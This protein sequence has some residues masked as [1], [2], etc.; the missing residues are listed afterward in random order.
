MRFSFKKIGSVLASTAMLTSTVALAAAANFPAPFVA[1]GAADVA[2][3]HGGANAAF[4]DLVAVTDIS[5]YLST[6]LAKQTATG[7]GGTGA[8]P[9]ITG[10]AAPLFSSGTKLYINDTLNAVKS[11]VTK[12]DL[13]TV[14]KDGSFSGNV[15]ASYTQAIDVGFNPQIIYA[16]KQPTSDLDP[17]FLVQ[18]STTTANYIYNASLT[19]SKAVALN[20]S[21]S[22]GQ[23][24][25]MFG[26]KFT[27]ASATGPTDLVLLKTA[28]KVALT[29]DDPSAEVTISGKTYTIELISAS[30]TAATVKVTDSDGKSETKEISENASKKVNGVTI[31]ITNAD[32]TNLRLSANVI[33]GAEKITIPGTQGSSVTMGEEETVIDGTAVTITGGVGAA[34][35]IVVSVRAP[36][37]DKDGILPGTSFK[38]PVFGSFKLD[39][40]GLSIKDDDTVNREDIKV[41]YNGDD[42]M[43]VAFTNKD[44]KTATVQYAK[45]W[46]AQGGIFGGIQLQRDSD[47]HNITIREGE[48][49]YK[50]NYVV[51]GNED[52]GKL[53]R[54]SQITNSTTAGTSG[55]KVQFVDIFS[56]DTIEAT[57]TAD[58]V[59][60]VSVGGKVYD[61]RYNGTSSNAENLV[62]LNYPDSSGTGGM[63]V[64]PT[65]QTKG[66]AKLSFYEPL[67]VPVTDWDNIDIIVSGG[68]GRDSGLSTLGANLTTIRFPDGDGYTDVTVGGN[69]NEGLFNITFGSTTTALNATGNAAGVASVSGAIGTLSYNISSIDTANPTATHWANDAHNS[70]LRI[71]LNNPDGGAAID[72]PAIVLFEEKDDNSLYQAII[73][74]TEPGGDSNDGVGV[75]DIKRTWQADGTWDAIALASNSKITKEA[76]LFG[77][78][79]TVD[80]GDSDQ[81]RGTINYPAEQVYANVY[82]AENA[83]EISAGQAG[84][85]GAT[86]VTSLGSV[87][88][89]DTEASSVATK[90]LV[91][92][93]GSCVNTV[94]SQ[95]LGLSGK[96]CGA[97]FTAKTGIGAGQ[98][99]IET[100]S[101]TGDKVATLVAG[102]NAGDTTNAAKYLTTQTVDTMVGKK[103]KGTSSTSAEL[104]TEAAAPA[105]A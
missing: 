49:L 69:R 71:R 1:S 91:V 43:E 44:G 73:V 90:N 96:T 98:F 67:I 93:G 79:A 22:E 33:A 103:Y 27:I 13:P 66:G 97:D 6:E 5:S 7:S 95:L 100:F 72:L 63:V 89:T 102:Y 9:T 81:Y 87:A 65:I 25:V 48:A 50:D 68:H 36:N 75:D 23:D 20:H 2:I 40:A 11:V 42:K 45:N 105:A 58:G 60:T 56:G 62:I 80:Q 51:V 53:L 92:I 85:G 30:D 64:Y 24:I 94:A 39:F 101:R 37:S 8:T 78:I 59:G 4:T 19:F 77:T 28:E 47:G 104:V 29:N 14:L 74:T 52:N 57:I 17:Q 41:G 86:G 82:V 35:K 70:S 38:D 61:V 34:T 10:E 12:S 32:E 16:G 46:T 55:D 76:D 84:S 88:V 83:A 54:V 31:A 18:T 26:Q 99:L 15:D 21:D 3:V